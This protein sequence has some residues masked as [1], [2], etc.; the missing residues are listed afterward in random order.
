MKVT[1][2]PSLTFEAM[3]AAAGIVSTRV[4]ALAD[5]LEAFVA[6]PD[7]AVQAGRT[8]RAA[9]LDRYGLGRFLADWDPLLGEISGC[10]RS[11]SESAITVI[12]RGRWD[13]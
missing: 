12:V 10:A 3:P 6:D 9:A 8:A 13:A 2:L 11:V 7:R 5:A 4:S 1:G